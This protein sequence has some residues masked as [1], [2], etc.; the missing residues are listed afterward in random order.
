MYVIVFKCMKQHYKNR[1]AALLLDISCKSD[2]YW[3]CGIKITEFMF[4]S[5]LN[6]LVSFNETVNYF[7]FSL[8]ICEVDMTVSIL[9]EVSEASWKRIFKSLKL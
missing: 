4:S 7:C 5:N 3:R 2:W 6:S 1:W 9:P 8:V